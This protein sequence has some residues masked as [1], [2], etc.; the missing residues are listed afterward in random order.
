M[1]DFLAREGLKNCQKIVIKIGS[2]ALVN[3]DG[4]NHKLISELAEE[5]E[6]IVKL[7]KQIIIVTSGAIALGKNITNTT[8]LSKQFYATIGQKQLIH[9]YGHCF[10]KVNLLTS[11]LLLT[12]TNFSEKIELEKLKLTITQAFELGII[13]IVN[14]NDASANN[15]FDNNDLLA[16]ELAKATSSDLLVLLTNTNGIYKSMETKETITYGRKHELDRYIL[17]ENS[18]FGTGGMR[19]KLIAS[20]IAGANTIIANAF[21]ENILTKILTGKDVGTLI[22]SNTN[23]K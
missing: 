23:T 1:M 19:T 21:E 2:N 9:E 16:A 17:E 22:N 14:E 8:H 12:K 15:S 5:I 11:Q 6:L 7:G 13:T 20:K 4:F 18:I 3:E 10:E